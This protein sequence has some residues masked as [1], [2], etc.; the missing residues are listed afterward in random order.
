VNRP[1]ASYG[2]GASGA[3]YQRIF[4]QG[5]DGRVV[6]DRDSVVV[7][8]CNVVELLL[9]LGM[10][11]VRLDTTRMQ[12]RFV[13]VAGNHLA[14][15]CA[16]GL[17]LGSWA[18]D[19]WICVRRSGPEDGVLHDYVL[20]PRAKHSGSSRGAPGPRSDK[21]SCDAGG[22]RPD[23]GPNAQWGEGGRRSK[24][25]SRGREQRQ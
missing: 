1:A 7:D 17:K 21:S 14:Q 15:V 24:T 10:L 16:V 23:N 4:V 18:F 6:N 12:G 2:I 20:I 22:A 19:V 13:N 9:E 5:S 8:V 3:A 11:A 25:W